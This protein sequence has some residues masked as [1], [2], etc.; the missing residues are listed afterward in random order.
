MEK[1]ETNAKTENENKNGNV[2]VNR[3]FSCADCAVMNCAKRNFVPR[4]N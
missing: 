2:N 1:K 4:Q 3:C